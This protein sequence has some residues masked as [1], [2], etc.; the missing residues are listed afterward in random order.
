[1]CHFIT[2]VVAGYSQTGLDKVMRRF[3][4]RAQTIE[5]QSVQNALRQDE[6]QYLTYG[7][8]C[9]CGTVL[10]R[11][12]NMQVGLEVHHTS[13][14][15]AKGWTDSK[16]QRWLEDKSKKDGFEHEAAIDGL[17]LWKDATDAILELP[18]VSAT[19]LLLHNYQGSVED[20]QFDVARR[21]VDK[22]LF[23]DCLAHFKEDELLMTQRTV[24]GR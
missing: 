10:A 9:D 2:L 15:K 14:L 12:H 19:G 21:L 5:N 20:E 17:Q 8:S 1:V 13:R 18:G 11:D 4:R 6:R 16:I 24:R 22:K 3:G 7:Q 23:D